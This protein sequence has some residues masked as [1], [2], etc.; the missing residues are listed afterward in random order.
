MSRP[1]PLR[2]HGEVLTMPV[3]GPLPA[4]VHN[5]CRKGFGTGS[6]PRVQDRRRWHTPSPMPPS[7]LRLYQSKLWHSL[8]CHSW[9]RHD[10]VRWRRFAFGRLVK[11]LMLH[12]DA[13]SSFADFAFCHASP[14][15]PFDPDRRSFPTHDRPHENGRQLVFCAGQVCR[16]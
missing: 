12:Q 13:N 10:V 16:L 9:E 5:S 3:L 8:S 7:L 14:N 1:P 11:S 6:M 15:A 4:Q 2:N